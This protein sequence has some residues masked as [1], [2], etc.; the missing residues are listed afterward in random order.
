M[1]T[2]PGNLGY[3]F[4]RTNTWAVVFSDAAF[5]IIT[6]TDGTKLFPASDV[7]FKEYTIAS[8]P[9][10]LGPA[11]ALSINNPTSVIKPT[12]V[13]IS[14]LDEQKQ[15][16]NAKI[17]DWILTSP[18]YLKSR[19]LS[20][21][22]SKYTKQ[23]TIYKLDIKGKPIPKYGKIVLDVFPTEE[24]VQVFSNDPSAQIDKLA[25]ACY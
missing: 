11:G 24:I 14:F 20:L 25:L 5:N 1:F 2:H 10:L 19:S 21:R 7:L 16:I 15:E 23:L 9:I 12:V 18:V 17:R 4:A 3:T 6:A 13:N 22:G 8:T